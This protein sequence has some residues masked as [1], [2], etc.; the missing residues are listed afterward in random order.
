MKPFGL[1]AITAISS[2]TILSAALTGCAATPSK[3]VTLTS[4]GCQDETLSHWSNWSYTM[5]AWR[6][7]SSE[8][9]GFGL[10][11][12]KQDAR[13]KFSFTPGGTNL[14]NTAN[15]LA[16]GNNQLAFTG[17][18]TLDQKLVQFDTA[19]T[20]TDQAITVPADTKF[21]PLAQ[22]TQ[23]QY[24]LTY[25]KEPVTLTMTI[26]VKG[27]PALTIKK[28]LALATDKSENPTPPTAFSAP[29]GA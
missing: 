9:S 19:L 13:I 23:S 8:I 17:L 25:G 26:Q 21:Q 6:H 29:K 28:T 10:F 2:L 3:P 12:C 18:H 27:K 1:K 4:I 14:V 22:L 7:G 15:Y 5:G 24:G 20:T 16:L 11:T